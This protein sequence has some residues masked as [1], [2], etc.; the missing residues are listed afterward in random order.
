MRLSI[1]Q[2]KQVG[3][4]FSGLSLKNNLHG[5]YVYQDLGLLWA[6]VRALDMKKPPRRRFFRP[7]PIATECARKGRVVE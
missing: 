6:F 5:L 4:R 7:K 2:K 1:E 3:T